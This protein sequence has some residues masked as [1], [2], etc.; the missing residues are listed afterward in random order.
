MLTDVN[1]ATFYLGHEVNA[2]QYAIPIFENEKNV[3]SLP[4]SEDCRRNV[5]DAD[6]MLGVSFAVVYVLG[7]FTHFSARTS[8]S[9]RTVPRIPLYGKIRTTTGQM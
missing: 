8:S 2:V 9:E 1:R 7:R 4:W 6:G 3:T 5:A